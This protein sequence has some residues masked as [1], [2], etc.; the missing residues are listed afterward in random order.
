MQTGIHFKPCNCGSAQAH[1]RREQQ[2]MEG[3]EHSGKKTYDIFHDRTSQN[4]S[5]TNPNYEGKSLVEIL[6]DC[7]AC[8]KQHVRQ[9]PQEKDRVRIVINKKT[10]LKKT[11]KRVGW[12]PIREGVCPVKASTTIADFFAFIRWLEKRGIHVI[13]IYIHRDEGYEDPVTGTRK[14]NYHAHIIADW[15]DYTTG[16]TAKLHQ[17]DFSEMQKALAESLQMECGVPKKVTGARHL[18]PAEQR[19]KAAAEHAIELQ[20]R[21]EELERKNKE[22]EETL[23]SSLERQKK[24][25]RVICLA[26]Q[27][28]GRKDVKIYDQLRSQSMKIGILKPETEDQKV[29]DDLYEHSNISV[30]SMDVSELMRE[31]SILQNLIIEMWNVIHRICAKISK[32]TLKLL[33]SSPKERLAHEIQLQAEK[34]AAI[35]EK[36]KVRGEAKE[37]IEERDHLK[38]EK[39]KWTIERESWLRDFENIASTL[40]HMSTPDQI[41]RYESRGL[42]KMIGPKLWAAAKSKKEAQSGSINNGQSQSGGLKK[43]R[44]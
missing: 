11:V 30:L 33:A 42:H 27:Y 14:Y 25:W 38:E 31:Q 26:Y 12:A 2:Y 9:N 18:T 44:R 37:A 6:D 17:K 39:E 4:L 13:S 43:S 1:N 5:W 10:G 34:D 16:R 40:I 32:I 20:A 15:M 36:N 22:L 41:L 7:R 3:L 23:K 8:Y 29:R 35:Q 28:S 21:N 24:Q 19:E